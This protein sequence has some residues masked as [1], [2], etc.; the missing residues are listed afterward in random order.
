MDDLKQAIKAGAGDDVVKALDRLLDDG[1]QAQELLDAMIGSLR[2]VGDAFSRGEAYI[3][4]MLIAA[5]AMQVGADR[6][7]DL[8]VQAGA[9]KAGK[10]VIGTVAG[11]LHDV[12]KNIVAL[13]FQGNGFDVVDLGVDL[14]VPRLLE[15]Y[16]TEAPDV[17]GLSALLTTTMPA[18]EEA[19]KA[20][21][22]KYPQARV[23]I[24]GAPIT[25]EFAKKIG[26][27]A[28]APDAASAV[29]IARQLLAG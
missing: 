15:S 17:V 12:G 23:L 3:P 27:D 1:L 16:E 20:L 29:E 19:V 10:L 4:E 24:G 22:E 7:S 25:D 18:M 5:K 11:D 14:A 6:L 8:L 26:A 21:K 2:E 13:V 9:K 28:Y